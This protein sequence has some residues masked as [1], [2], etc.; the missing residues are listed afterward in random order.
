MSILFEIPTIYCLV[1]NFA[2]MATMSLELF[3]EECSLGV[4]FVFH[5]FHDTLVPALEGLFDG[6]DVKG[7]RT[8][9]FFEAFDHVVVDFRQVA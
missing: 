1:T 5:I 8:I 3:R 9:A 7:L 4:V 6:L 2:T